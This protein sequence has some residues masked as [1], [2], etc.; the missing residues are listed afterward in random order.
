MTQIWEYIQKISKRN[1]SQNQI[2]YIGNVPTPLEYI[3]KISRA[4][5]MQYNAKYEMAEHPRFWPNLPRR[6][7]TS[8]SLGW[9]LR[10]FR[11][12][13]LTWCSCRY[14]INFVWRALLGSRWLDNQLCVRRVPTFCSLYMLHG[15]FSLYFACV[16]HMLFDS[17]LVALCFTHFCVFTEGRP[18]YTGTIF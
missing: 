8:I 14:V 5:H 6:P 12:N 15:C 10:I 18:G 2:I 3:F 11:H 1:N 13:V 16:L 4:S 9:A 17:I 7:L